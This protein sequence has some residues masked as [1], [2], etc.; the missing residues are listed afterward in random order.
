MSA[1]LAQAFG[2]LD[3]GGDAPANNASGSRR[4]ARA[5]DT[6]GTGLAGN[7]EY[8]ESI[9]AQDVSTVRKHLSRISALR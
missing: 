4:E 2:R 7:I 1:I 5:F 9:W 3:A 6:E 8:P